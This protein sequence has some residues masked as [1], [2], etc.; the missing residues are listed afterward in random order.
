M[1]YS[2]MMPAFAVDILEVGA[3]GQGLL[4]SLGGVGALAAIMLLGPMGGSSYRGPLIV[5]GGLAFGL[6]VT[7]FALTSEFVGSYS[8]ALVLMFIM[9]ST[10]TIYVVAIISSLQQLVPANIRGRVMGFTSI[11][12]YIGP[13][14]AFQ[15]GAIAE[16]VG[17]S[18][19]VAIGG[20]LVTLFALGPAIINR[21][22]RNLGVILQEREWT[23][24]S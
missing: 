21:Q 9:G 11:T 6:A 14:G 8:L 2:Q 5:G 7:A 22:I 24:R 13:I 18:A 12:W 4:M 1:S 10:S 3:D 19:A 17:V 15:T 16:L 23:G 20:T